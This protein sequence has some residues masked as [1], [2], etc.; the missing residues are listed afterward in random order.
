MP[1]PHNYAPH[2]FHAPQQ[3][4]RHP[5]L[6]LLLD[7]YAV[8][9][10]SVAVAVAKAPAQLACKAGCAECCF[11]PIPVLPLEV[12]GLAC[13]LRETDAGQ[14]AR[15]ALAYKPGG[16]ACP[17]LRAG[18]CLVYALRPMA[19]RR[20]LVCGAPCAPGEDPVTVRPQ[21][22]L[23]PGRTVFASALAITAPYYKEQGL[24]HAEHPALE[25]FL[26]LTTMMQTVPWAAYES[27]SV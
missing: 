13:F 8:I 7:A 6:A 12:L 15:R 16:A 14:E 18:N 11:Q 9:D 22:V 26:R 24:L 20:Y 17:F 23:L 27:E 3:E 5:W 1:L 25:D 2:R 19:C 21:D 10:A 4:R